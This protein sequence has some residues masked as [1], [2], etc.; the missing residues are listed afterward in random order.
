MT[1][2]LPLPPPRGRG[3]HGSRCRLPLAVNGS[4]MAETLTRANT[5]RPHGSNPPLPPKERQ[6]HCHGPM[7][8]VDTSKEQTQ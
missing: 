5:P 2:A 3:W 8:V 6:H 1:R 4:A 7:A